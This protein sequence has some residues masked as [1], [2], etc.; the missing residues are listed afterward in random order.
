MT[1]EQLWWSGVQVLYIGQASFDGMKCSQA[2][3][4]SGPLNQGTVRAT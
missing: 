1:M 2:A 3:P 4:G